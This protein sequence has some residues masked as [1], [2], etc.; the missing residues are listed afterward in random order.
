VEIGFDPTELVTLDLRLGD[1]YTPETR[2]AFIE[3]VFERIRQIPGTRAV[4]A[5]VTLPF[6]YEGG[7][8]C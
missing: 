2:P 5:G 8:T 7:G 1:R 4:V 6:Q 3:A